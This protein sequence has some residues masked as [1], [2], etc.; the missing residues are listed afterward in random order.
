MKRARLPWADD[1]EKPC[2]G[3]P[4]LGIRALIAEWTRPISP[5]CK[6]FMTRDEIERETEYE[7]AGQRI[8]KK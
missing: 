8:K 6:P 2:K 5:W 4:P 3:R 1:D 7:I